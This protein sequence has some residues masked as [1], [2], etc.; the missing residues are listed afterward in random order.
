MQ[1]F[2]RL[3]FDLFV[4]FNKVS[5]LFE[6]RAEASPTECVRQGTGSK[7]HLATAEH[8]GILNVAVKESIHVTGADHTM[9]HVIEKDVR[10]VSCLQ[11]V[12]RDTGKIRE[13]VGF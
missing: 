1:V 7:N 13:A 12:D 10:E 5:D 2:F 9:N 8:R 3:N 11:V 6:Q 4:R